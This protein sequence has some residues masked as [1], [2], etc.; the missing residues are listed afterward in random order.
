MRLSEQNKN[1]NSISNHTDCFTQVVQHKT[2]HF[3]QS[4]HLQVPHKVNSEY[5]D[6]FSPWETR[7]FPT[8]FRFLCFCPGTSFK[9][10]IIFISPPAKTLSKTKS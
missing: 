7:L 4:Y 1:T 6:C 3:H 8:I 9:S 5:I 2:G 10:C